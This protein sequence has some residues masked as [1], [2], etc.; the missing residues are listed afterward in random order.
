MKILKYNHCEYKFTV[1][2]ISNIR[3]HVVRLTGPANDLN[4]NIEFR[5][6]NFC[7]RPSSCLLFEAPYNL[8]KFIILLL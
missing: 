5:Y 2:Y 1:A 7:L 3:I 8:S 4:S 6:R